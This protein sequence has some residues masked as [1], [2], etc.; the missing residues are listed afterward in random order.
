MNAW[1]FL[2]ELHKVCHFATREAKRGPNGMTAS[3]S[4]IKR[5]LM[6]GAVLFNG[7]KVAWDEPIDFPVFSL[8]LFPKGNKVTLW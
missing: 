3:S 4:E 2:R 5:W 8:V 7:E 1:E 6:N